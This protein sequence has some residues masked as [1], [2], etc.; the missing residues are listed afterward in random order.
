M[1]NDDALYRRLTALDAWYRG[2]LPGCV[3]NLLGRSLLSADSARGAAQYAFSLPTLCRNS[4]GAAHGGAVS[5]VFD[6]ALS[7]LASGVAGETERLLPTVSLQVSFFLPV[8]IGQ[9]LFL[10]AETLHRGK[11]LLS[12]RAELHQKNGKNTPLSVAEATFY[13]RRNP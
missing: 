4:T 6:N 8:P 10:T 13:Q 12:L 1:T 2:V 3:Q 7:L 5:T 11:T 9:S